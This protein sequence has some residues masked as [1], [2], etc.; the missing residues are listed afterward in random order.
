MALKWFN[1]LQ[2]YMNVELCMMRYMYTQV[3]MYCGIHLV[4][5]NGKR[6]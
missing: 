2:L 3:P 6:M 1:S 4:D 5:V